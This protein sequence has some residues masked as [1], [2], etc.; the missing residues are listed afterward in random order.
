MYQYDKPRINKRRMQGG[1]SEEKTPRLEPEFSRYLP[2]IT[3]VPA[4]TV[5]EAQSPGTLER[6]ELVTKVEVVSGRVC[7]MVE[8]MVTTVVEITVE[9]NVR[10]GD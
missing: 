8:K 9:Y 2:G 7:T 10:V 6:H 4:I 3:V 5:E 1:E